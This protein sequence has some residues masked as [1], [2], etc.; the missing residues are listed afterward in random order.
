MSIGVD[1][2]VGF[3]CICGVM[4]TYLSKI[5]FSMSLL[6]IAFALVTPAQAARNVGVAPPAIIIKPKALSSRP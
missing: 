3:S 4:K 1:I 6:G 2:W 5:V